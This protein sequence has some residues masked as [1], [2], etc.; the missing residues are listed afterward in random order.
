MRMKEYQDQLFIIQFQ[1]I[2]CCR[3]ENKSSHD[4]QILS[5]LILSALLIRICSL[6]PITGMSHY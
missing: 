5:A 2:L 3:V 1:D 4:D 6:Q